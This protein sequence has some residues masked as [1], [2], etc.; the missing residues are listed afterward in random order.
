VNKLANKSDWLEVQ[1]QAMPRLELWQ[2]GKCFGYCRFDP[3]WGC[4]FVCYICG[5][6]IPRTEDCY[7]RTVAST[8]ATLEDAQG[9][10]LRKLGRP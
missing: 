6:T 4:Y 2:D 3:D 10:L 1:A 9:W 5:G 8:K 7:R